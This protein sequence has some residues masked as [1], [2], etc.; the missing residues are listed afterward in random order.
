MF[1]TVYLGLGSNLGDKKAYMDGAIEALSSTP[2][3]DVE[4]VSI[5][6]SVV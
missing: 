3:I 4:K 6:N 5:L 1:E 2:H